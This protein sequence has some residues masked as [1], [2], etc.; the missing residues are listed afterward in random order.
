LLF[1]IANLDAMSLLASRFS[2]RFLR[3]SS[4]IEVTKAK[5]LVLQESWTLMFDY[6]IETFQFL[7]LNKYHGTS[8]PSQNSVYPVIPVK[9]FW[10]PIAI[11]AGV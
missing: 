5:A 7:I 10:Q 1:S 6:K 9:M 4:F 8:C 2:N 11:F 3:L